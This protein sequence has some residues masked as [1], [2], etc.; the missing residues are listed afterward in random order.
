MWVN[1]ARKASNYN[2]IQPCKSVLV[3]VAVPLCS[4]GGVITAVFA[5]SAFCLFRIFPV[6]WWDCPNAISVTAKG[7]NIEYAQVV[8]CTVRL[9]LTRHHNSSLIRTEAERWA[10]NEAHEC[11]PVIWAVFARWSRLWPSWFLLH[12]CTNNEHTYST[13]IFYLL[14][15]HQ[16]HIRCKHPTYVHVWDIGRPGPLQ[17]KWAVNEET[18]LQ[19]TLDCCVSG[20]C[21]WLFR[22]I[23]FKSS[24]AY[25]QAPTGERDVRPSGNL[26]IDVSW[27]PAGKSP[28][29]D[30]VPIKNCEIFNRFTH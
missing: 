3:P 22:S 18:G 17:L 15:S 10:L 4:K 16:R 8:F 21:F 29:S 5:F 1:K 19:K 12:A 26:P 2:T 25:P 6:G 11:V 7:T 24:D 13:P 27:N 9:G 23:P 30:P 28:R 20:N 14:Y